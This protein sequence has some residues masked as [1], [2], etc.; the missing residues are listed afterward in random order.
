MLKFMAFSS[1]FLLGCCCCP[2]A[3][4]TATSKNS[5]PIICNAEP[6]FIARENKTFDH[7][8]LKRGTERFSNG[9]YYIHFDGG[10]L[11]LSTTITVKDNNYNCVK[12]LNRSVRLLPCDIIS[13]VSIVWGYC[14]INWLQQFLS[15]IIRIVYFGLSSG[16]W[17]DSLSATVELLWYRT[18]K[19]LRP[20]CSISQ[21][22]SL[23]VGL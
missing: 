7:P 6:T 10:W 23:F 1:S 21:T 5:S 2:S 17:F 15:I 11:A 19:K 4:T 20:I 12:I 16:H 3:A 8:Q 22:I 9:L 13:L 14:V 18:D